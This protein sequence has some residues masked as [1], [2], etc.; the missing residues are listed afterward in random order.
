MT[1]IALLRAIQTSKLQIVKLLR[2]RYLGIKN[3]Q[4]PHLTGIANIKH[5][6]RKMLRQHWL[7]LIPGR[8]GI[9]MFKYS[10][11]GLIKM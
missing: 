2:E 10:N 8:M 9:F 4:T 6:F 7:Q 11:L 5:G 1:A 3:L